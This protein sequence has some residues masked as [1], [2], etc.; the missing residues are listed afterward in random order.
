MKP[1]FRIFGNR[2]LVV[3]VEVPRSVSKSPLQFREYFEGRR[4]AQVEVP[5]VAH[6]CRFPT[7]IDASPRVPREA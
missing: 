5:E 3:R 6:Y 1:E 4:K 2:N 7:A